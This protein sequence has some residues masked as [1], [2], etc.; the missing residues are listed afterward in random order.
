MSMTETLI[1][2]GLNMAYDRREVSL[3]LI[4]HSDRDAQYR[5]TGYQDC[6]RSRDFESSKSRSERELLGQRPDGVVFQLAE[7]GTDLRRVF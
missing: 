6:L 3:G 2:D 1:S 5:S 7:S 4:V